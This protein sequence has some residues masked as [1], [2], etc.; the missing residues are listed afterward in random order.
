MDAWLAVR[1]AIQVEQG[2]NG[3]GLAT[4]T[5]SGLTHDGALC[6]VWR[7]D[8]RAKCIRISWWREED[9]RRSKKAFPVDVHSR[10]IIFPSIQG[11]AR[12]WPNAYAG[13]LVF[14]LCPNI[15]L[16]A[17]KFNSISV[18]GPAGRFFV[19]TDEKFGRTE[20]YRG[21]QRR[22]FR[23]LWSDGPRRYRQRTKNTNPGSFCIVWKQARIGSASSSWSNGHCGTV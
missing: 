9:S 12:R 7:I 13:Q 3:K 23:R 21:R 10:N 19:G 8:G 16:S 18:Y 17:G 15:M 2:S 1:D 22:L 4:P 14:Q 11:G 5:A 20:C 6:T